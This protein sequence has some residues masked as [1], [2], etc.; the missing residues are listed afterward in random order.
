MKKAIAAV[1][2]MLAAFQV[3]PAKLDSF[4]KDFEFV[5]K[6]CAVVERLETSADYRKDFSLR[7]FKLQ[8]DANDIQ[9]VATETG[10]R[11][12]EIG[13]F[14]KD[15]IST[16]GVQKKS[17]PT[18][19]MLSV[20]HFSANDVRRQ[21][22]YLK[23]LHFSYEERVFKPTRYYHDDLNVMIRFLRRWEQCKKIGFSKQSYSKYA[24]EQYRQRYFKEIDRLARLI[25][26]K[27]RRDKTEISGD[28]RLVHH[29]SLFVQNWETNSRFFEKNSRS[30]TRLNITPEISSRIDEMKLIAVDVEKD[31]D[32][33][34]AAGFSMELPDTKFARDKEKQMKERNRELQKQEMDLSEARKAAKPQ[35]KKTPPP[36]IDRKE[37]ARIYS[38]KKQTVYDS[39][40][41]MNGVSE[42][43]YRNYLDLLP[44]RQQKEM[45]KYKQEYIEKSYPEALA[46]ST[47]VKKIHLKYDEKNHGCTDE[48][49]MGILNVKPG[50]IAK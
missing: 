43:L 22:R 32:L 47:A 33:L 17:V 49:M 41:K 26:Q 29:V 50:D 44:E 1:L 11:D 30:N 48:E 45:E 10:I 3:F 21:I 9:K 46:R 13:K 20:R 37:L 18:R 7:V 35:K 38:R 12:I 40:S 39:E 42:K 19:E 8:S 27:I 24:L 15:L 31:L 23:D 2:C 34:A 4:E 14:V 5:Y 16:I 25:E 36:K 28:F 6:N